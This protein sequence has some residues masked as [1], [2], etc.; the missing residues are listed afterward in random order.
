[1][2]PF[3]GGY[4]GRGGVSK[5]MRS[6]NTWRLARLIPHSLL[7]GP[8]PTLGYAVQP[9]ATAPAAPGSCGGVRSAS[10]IEKTG[11]R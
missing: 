7:P 1:M 11:N 9:G 8:E 6:C 10:P 5:L 3:A 2:P 4:K